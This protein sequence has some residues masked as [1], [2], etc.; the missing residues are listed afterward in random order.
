MRIFRNQKISHYLIKLDR[1]G[2]TENKL[3]RIF[4]HAIVQKL[5]YYLVGH[6]EDNELYSLFLLRGILHYRIYHYL[7]DRIQKTLIIQA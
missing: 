5:V 7:Y 2:S 1:N 6:P 3:N 4:Y